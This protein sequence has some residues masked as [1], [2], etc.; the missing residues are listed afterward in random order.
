M[1]SSETG[2]KPLTKQI[3]EH[4]HVHVTTHSWQHPTQDQLNTA[5][6]SSI[7]AQHCPTAALAR[8]AQLIPLGQGEGAAQSPRMHLH[9]A[10]ATVNAL[11]Q[12]TFHSHTQG[13]N[14]AYFFPKW[15]NICQIVSGCPY[16]HSN[17]SL[18]SSAL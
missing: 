5:Q 17:L 4:P 15:E 7:T 11:G 12:A 16:K 9:E 14:Y 1:H 10:A 13:K 3:Q 6:L 8:A 2:E 18:T